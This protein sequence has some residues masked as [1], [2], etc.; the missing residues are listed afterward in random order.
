MYGL[1]Q[2]KVFL[3]ANFKVETGHAYSKILLPPQPHFSWLSV[4]YRPV[5][6]GR[7]TNAPI[8]KFHITG[9]WP[10]GVISPFKQNCDINEELVALRQISILNGVS[11]LLSARHT[12]DP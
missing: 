2:D 11:K 4:A 6:K 5:I 10:T 3:A 7:K 9:N 1:N 8:N 12:C